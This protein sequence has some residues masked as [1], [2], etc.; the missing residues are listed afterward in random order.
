M[1]F[2]LFLILQL[3]LRILIV[4]L[5]ILTQSTPNS[6][7]IKPVILVNK[8]TQIKPRLRNQ[9][10]Q[11][12]KNTIKSRLTQSNPDPTTTNQHN[13]TTTTPPPR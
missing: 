13:Q 12:Q 10:Q 9:S 2:N 4:L 5:Q 8:P 6:Q 7:Q 3:V 11:I 1:F